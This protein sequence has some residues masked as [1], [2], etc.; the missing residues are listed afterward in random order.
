MAQLDE[1]NMGDLGADEDS[2]DEEEP[3]IIYPDIPEIDA[4]EV[5]ALR[6][7]TSIIKSVH[8]DIVGH[9]GCYVTLQ[10]ILKH[11]KEWSSRA[12]MLRDV[13]EFISGCPT[14]Q[15]F[16]KRHDR[17]TDQRFFIEG[18]PFAEISVDIL[19]LPSA[20]CYGNAYIVNIVDT[21]TRFVFAVPV[22]DKTAIN[23][24]RAI[25]Q[26]IGIFGAPLT[27]RSD[28]GG[29]F[30]G[31]VI[32]SIEVMTGV[33]HHRIQ[34]YIHTGNSIVERANRSVLEHMRT[35]IWDKRLLF[36]GEHMWSDILP[37]ACRIINASFNS[38]IGC[39][40]ASLLF[41][42]NVDMDRCILSSPPRPNTS[43]SFDYAAQL[44]ANQRRLLEA[45]DEFQDRSHAKMLAKWRETHK[46]KDQLTA[47]A[48]HC[49]DP[50]NETSTWVVA[51]V[52]DDAPHNKL[53]PRWSGP[54][55]LMG[56]KSESVSM[57]KLWDTVSKKVR[58]APLNSVALWDCKFGDAPDV[59][60][61]IR[62]SDYA[63]LSYPMEA[64][65]GVALDTKDADIQPTPLPANY[66]R[67]RPKSDYVFSVKWRGYH[68]PTWRP[69][70]VV[71]STSLFPLFAAS[72]PDLNL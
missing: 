26:S 33:K 52:P 19:N 25:L 65:L 35:L 43:N 27:I 41:G 39:S 72:R 46:G 15:K 14:C 49:S 66:V 56:F 67:T 34:P 7:P 48:E 53:K 12:Q 40:P 13:D 1:D 57:L 5:N 58:E 68:E 36:N 16:R 8:G 62:E 6:D 11:K 50:Q 3:E 71:K 18:S 61:G 29:E 30:V 54:Y 10:R 44:S 51:K 28:G 20:D 9:G 4:A 59:L 23:A 21:F 2:D 38:S 63:D 24:G 45:S 60:T 69:Y 17:A 31:D 22:P 37:M 64:I 42:D 70:R 55:I 32:K 47:L